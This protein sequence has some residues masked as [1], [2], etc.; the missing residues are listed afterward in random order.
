MSD[1]FIRHLISFIAMLVA[2][3]AYFSG[4][5]SGINGWWWTVLGLG[6]FYFIIYK[7]VEA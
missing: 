4:Y 7:L 3:L 5:V 2:G 6:L 1:N